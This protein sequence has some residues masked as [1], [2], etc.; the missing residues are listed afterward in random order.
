MM[1]GGREGAGVDT[2]S[3]GGKAGKAG[4]K[5]AAYS[6]EEGHQCRP[7]GGSPAEP[8][9][10]KHQI[11]NYESQRLVAPLCELIREKKRRR[12]S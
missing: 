12:P 6:H 2:E 5:Q 1:R 3:N 10:Q 8:Q 11:E 9:G 7:Q 4:G